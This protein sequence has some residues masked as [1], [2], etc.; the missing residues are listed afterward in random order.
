MAGTCI[1]TVKIIGVSS[2]GLLTS[3][4][5]YQSFKAIPLLIHDLNNKVQ[6]LSDSG[7][8]SKIK[9]L[10]KR[11][12]L[13]YT[14]LS[15]TAATFLLLAFKESPPSG[16]HPY[17]IYS[18]LI[19]PVVLGALYWKGRPVESKILAKRSLTPSNLERKEDNLEESDNGQKSDDE[20]Q[21]GK[22]Y[23]HVSEEDSS[24]TSTPTSSTP[25]SPR[26]P[27]AQ[28]N[29]R[30]VETDQEIENVLEK[31]AFLHDLN[32][33]KRTYSAAAMI[34]GFGFFIASLGLFGDYFLL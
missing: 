27:S 3:S 32:D 24:T 28:E 12:R 14:T 4:L 6:G 5:A 13:G 15:T 26:A 34:S 11:A 31:K 20:S 23:I 1:A 18:A 17:L 8:A 7:I 30:H 33:L 21:L 10:I 29:L 22:S 25:S 2:L 9:R 19:S 16:K